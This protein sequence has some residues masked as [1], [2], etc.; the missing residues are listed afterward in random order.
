[1]DDFVRLLER[2]FIPGDVIEIRVLSLRGGKARGIST[3]NRI[4][5]FRYPHDVDAMVRFLENAKR[6]IERG[7]WAAHGVYFSVN[8]REE[9]KKDSVGSKAT[10]VRYGSTL[11]IDFDVF[12]KGSESSDV[13]LVVEEVRVKP[14]KEWAV[15][16]KETAKR[17]L[18]LLAVNVYHL[19]VE[20]GMAP[21][22]ITDSGFGIHMFFRLNPLI[23]RNEELPNPLEQQRDFENKYREVFEAVKSVLIDVLEEVVTV[24]AEGQKVEETKVIAEIIDNAVADVARITR[25]PGIPNSKLAYSVEDG[26]ITFDPSRLVE[27][28]VL[29]YDI[30]ENELFGHNGL[31][32]DPLDVEWLLREYQKA[33]GMKK[34]K[35]IREAQP[36]N[37]DTPILDAVWQQMF[38]KYDFSSAISRAQGLGLVE[39]EDENTVRTLAKTLL[40][41]YPPEGMRHNFFLQFPSFFLLRGLGPKTVVKIF[42]L[43]LREAIAFGWDE[44]KEVKDR[45][46]ATVEAVV[47]FISWKLGE[48]FTKPPAGWR[49][50]IFE[51]PE[52]RE[53]PRLRSEWR[54]IRERLAQMPEDLRQGLGIRAVTGEQGLRRH[55]LKTLASLGMLIRSAIE[56][57]EGGRSKR[58]KTAKSPDRDKARIKPKILHNFEPRDI[59]D[60]VLHKLAEV[61]SPEEVDRKDEVVQVWEELEYYY[62]ELLSPY[63]EKSLVLSI[64]KL[65]EE[66][67]RKPS[68]LALAIKFKNGR[69]EL[70]R[71][72]DFKIYVLDIADTN[73]PVLIKNGKE[74][75]PNLRPFM[76]LNDVLTV[77]GSPLFLSPDTAIQRLT[78][79]TDNEDRREFEG[80]YAGFLD[81]VL[82]GYYSLVYRTLGEVIRELAERA[83]IEVTSELEKAAVLFLDMLARAPIVVGGDISTV[84]THMVTV[85]P[86][87]EGYEEW[88]II[89]PTRVLLKLFKEMKELVAGVRF[90]N[91]T[92]VLNKVFLAEER[93]VRD[94]TEGFQGRDKAYILRLDRIKEVAEAF[95]PSPESFMAVILEAIEEAE[96]LKLQKKQELVNYFLRL[97]EEYGGVDI[98][99]IQTMAQD[100]EISREILDR[101]K[102]ELTEKGYTVEEIQDKNGVGL[103]IV[104]NRETAPDGMFPGT[105]EAATEGGGAQ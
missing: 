9:V 72:G 8:P 96:A 78:R 104:S 38:E 43:A 90:E 55:I 105:A 47:N 98:E 77:L 12:K 53:N 23:V 34:P 10:D 31:E 87:K 37:T 83:N 17:F 60:K 13:W 15:R 81:D 7:T 51:N 28:R 30:E 21:A 69:R 74:K 73:I 1:M 41:I 89:M 68:S 14:S 32:N 66:R 45:A 24:E 5:H 26:E 93:Y 59:H 56:G 25:V 79:M 61:Y 101:I 88:K 75:S 35:G 91:V 44:E 100:P 11:F 4:K 6:R 80:R 48:E 33:K 63:Y 103:R 70:I 95:L 20:R 42:A 40:R 54:A 52:E 27:T 92:D 36:S 62:R 2:M 39:I 19:L 29:F 50:V 18:E 94:R 85:I 49:S 3:A 64:V 99:Q 82:Q 97:A 84:D 16:N 71:L 86:G 46:A 57:S 22:I 76:G 102:Q 65:R 58:K 67:G